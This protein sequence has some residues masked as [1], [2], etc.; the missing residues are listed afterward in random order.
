M[1]K[2]T[3]HADPNAENVGVRIYYVKKLDRKPC[4]SGHGAS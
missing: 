2:D 1:A 3:C 4:L